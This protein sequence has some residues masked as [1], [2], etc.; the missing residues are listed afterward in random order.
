MH[1]LT[2]EQCIRQTLFL[3]KASKVRCEQAKEQEASQPK[4]QPS[5]SAYRMWSAEDNCHELA[6]MVLKNLEECGSLPDHKPG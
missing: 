6:Q 3:Q 2:F 4:K 5:N 1:K